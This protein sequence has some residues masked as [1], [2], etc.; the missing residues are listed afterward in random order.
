MGCRG[1]V[2]E[3]PERIAPV[4]LR[5]RYGEN[6]QKDD[7]TPEI[8]FEFDRRNISEW[9]ARQRHGMCRSLI[10]SKAGVAYDRG[11]VT[12]LEATRVLL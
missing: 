12:D 9:F 10:N 1:S 3:A 2:S 7:E 11:F 4:D 8:H 5:S 6:R